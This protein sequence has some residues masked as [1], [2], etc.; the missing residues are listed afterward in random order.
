[1]DWLYVKRVDNF[2]KMSNLSHELIKLLEENF[3][4]D[5]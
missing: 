5:E 1:M 3:F 4:F 2:S